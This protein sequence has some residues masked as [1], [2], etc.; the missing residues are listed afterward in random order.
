MQKKNTW[1][2]SV[3]IL[4]IVLVGGYLLLHKSPKSPSSTYSTSTSSNSTSNSS[5]ATTAGE[6][7]N[8]VLKTK[9]SS[10]LGS[11]L[12]DPNGNT[13]YTVGA[14]VTGVSACSSSC[15]SAWPAYLDKGAT[16]GLPTNVDTIKRADNG[17][18]QYM[19]R[20][21]PLY[22]FA[23]DKTGQVTGNGVA[24]FTLARP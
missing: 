15:L 12:T 5:K 16:T 22:Y 8:A 18:I 24:G 19:Y 20:G 2:V 17:E 21:L 11:Y 9:S 6:V 13:L 4:V 23:S 7:N 1:I 3:V 14:G 10:S